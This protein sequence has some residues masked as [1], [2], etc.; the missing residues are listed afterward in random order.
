MV[1]SD[2]RRFVTLSLFSTYYFGNTVYVV[3]IAQ[4]LQQVN[5]KFIYLYFIGTST[6][7]KTPITTTNM[8]PLQF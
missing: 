1:N 2:F 5:K 3:L 7:K 8:L 6:D 4:T